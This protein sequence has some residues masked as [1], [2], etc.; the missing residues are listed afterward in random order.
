MSEPIF[1][2]RPKLTIVPLRTQEPQSR[3]GMI[4]DK[5]S[6]I[7][8]WPIG[9]D[10]DP[11][12][13]GPP[14]RPW[15]VVGWVTAEANL[16]NGLTSADAG[17]AWANTTTKAMHVWQGYR[18]HDP[19]PT[20]LSR[21]GDPGAP[22]NITVAPATTLDVGSNVTATLTG[23]A[24][25]RVL[26]VGIPRGAP[27]DKGPV[28]PPQLT[29]AVDYV[30]LPPTRGQ[31]LAWSQS[32]GGWVSVRLGTAL[33]Q[34]SIIDAEF[35]NSSLLIGPSGQSRIAASI[36]LAPLP[37]PYRLLCSGHVAIT[38]VISRSTTGT[39]NDSTASIAVDMT[40]GASAPVRIGMGKS[41]RYDTESTTPSA[42]M[43]DRIIVMDA[44]ATKLTPA[45]ADGVVPANKTA[46]VTV[47]LSRFY[48]NNGGSIR[49]PPEGGGGL[50]GSYLRLTGLAV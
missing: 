34:W 17:K 38:H 37:V 7:L 33:A 9:P 40:T 21:P 45:S 13:Q 27:G 30:G 43:S 29:R 28:S 22:V 12:P 44:S 35:D 1:E 23:D 19:I 42:G 31:S 10:G 25:D 24:P 16:P 6:G 11:G 3:V 5:K 46:T 48:S 50:G 15:K 8:E 20:G 39:P 4:F 26:S 47:T 49:I 2:C 32:L 14:S 41:T 36:E 18:W